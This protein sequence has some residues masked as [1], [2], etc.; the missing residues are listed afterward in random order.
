MSA[1]RQFLRT[2]VAAGAGAALHAFAPARAWAARRPSYPRR[3]VR[4][5]S[6]ISSLP[7]ASS[8]LPVAGHCRPLSTVCCPAPSCAFAKARR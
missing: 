8:A 4:R 5:P 3:L 6:P 2:G 1:R 7:N